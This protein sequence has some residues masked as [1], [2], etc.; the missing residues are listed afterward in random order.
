MVQ[1]LTDLPFIIT[2]QAPHWL[3]SQP[4]C[5]PVSPSPSRMWWTSRV[6]GSTSLSRATP[7]TVIETLCAIFPP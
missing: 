6:R 3:V 5:V 1:D 7:F 4:M 2:V